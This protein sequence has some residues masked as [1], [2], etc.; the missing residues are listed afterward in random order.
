MQTQMP[1]P[2][3]LREN[4]SGLTNRGATLLLILRM[5]TLQLRN[6]PRLKEGGEGQALGEDTK[7]GR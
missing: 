5:S 1:L 4:G 2:W 7:G 6:D 3:Q